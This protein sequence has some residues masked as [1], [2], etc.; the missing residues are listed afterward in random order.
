[1]EL[2]MRQTEETYVDLVHPETGEVL[3]TQHWVAEW[4]VRQ[5]WKLAESVEK[6]KKGA[7]D[8]KKDDKSR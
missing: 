1:M 8:G 3:P 4:L 7:G 5:G 2:Q 6:L